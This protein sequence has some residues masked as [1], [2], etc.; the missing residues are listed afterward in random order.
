MKESSQLRDQSFACWLCDGE[1]VV[2]ETYAKIPL[3]RCQSCGFLFAPQRNLEEL[4]ELYDDSYFAEYPGGESYDADEDQRKYEASLRIDWIRHYVQSGRVLEI[5]AAEGGFLE[6]MRD[7]GFSVFG[8][9][10]AEGLAQIARDQRGID[11]RAGF[12]EDVELPTEPF[13]I[14]CAW[15]VLEHITK[16]HASI[17]RLRESIAEDGKFFIEI[18]NIESVKAKRTT[19]EWFHLDPRHHVAFYNEAQ[20]GKLLGDCGF[21]LIDTSSIS[22]FS[23]LR[24]GR[25][26]RPAELAARGLEAATTR[27]LP[28]RPHPWKH[29]LLRAV[30]V[31]A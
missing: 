28:N 15:H 20:L 13:D 23:Y 10:P 25:A 2:S 24:P 30:A 8:V 4:H 31:P 12:I 7:A 26:L 16:P 19:T 21:E 6:V 22:G 17:R 11:V 9:E 18:P 5:G 27:T 14:V 3:F 29:E 1:A